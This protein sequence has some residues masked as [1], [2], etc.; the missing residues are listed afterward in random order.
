MSQIKILGATMGTS[1]KFLTERPQI[2]VSTVQ[3]L[4]AWGDLTTKICAPL[5]HNYE[6]LDTHLNVDDT[7][8]EFY[9]KN[10]L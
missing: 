1:R 4:F 7:S 2:L 5:S 8:T 10:H 6:R 9:V 3:K